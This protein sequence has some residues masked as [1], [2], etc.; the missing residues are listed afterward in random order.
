[1]P[2]RGDKRL[3]EAGAFGGNCSFETMLG[4]L[5]NFYRRTARQK[6]RVSL[7]ICHHLVGN[8]NGHF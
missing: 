5:L 3:R 1:M 4:A 7:N 2:I 6:L 8:F